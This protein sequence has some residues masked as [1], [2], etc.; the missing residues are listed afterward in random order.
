MAK[1]QKPGAIKFQ[2]VTKRNG[3]EF[4]RWV[5]VGVAWPHDATVS[6]EIWFKVLPSTELVIFWNEDGEGGS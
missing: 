5:Q 1:G 3:K 2:L 6:M 4:K